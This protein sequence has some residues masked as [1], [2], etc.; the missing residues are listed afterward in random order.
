MSR[1]FVPPFAAAL[2]V[3]LALLVAEPSPTRAEPKAF[4]EGVLGFLLPLG[5]DDYEN[6]VD[7]GPKLGLRAG[8]AVGSLGFELGLDWEP[9]QHDLG[10]ETLDVDIHRLRALVGVRGL[11]RLAGGGWGFVRFAAGIDHVMTSVEGTVLGFAV[12]SEEDDTGLALEP[13]VG[14]VFPLG[15][16]ALG[17]QLGLPMSFHDEDDSADNDVDF[18][19]TSFDLDVLF[20]L[21]TSL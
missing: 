4:F 12:E 8:A 11:L 13:G 2:V 16:V 18:D 21:S 19:Y 15:G 1:R 20:T 14:I 10:T 6:V 5:D 9:I 3:A 17:G 7:P